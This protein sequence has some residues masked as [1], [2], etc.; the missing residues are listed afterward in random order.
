MFYEL[1]RF[2][3]RLYYTES[4]IITIIMTGHYYC[5][6]ILFS[7]IAICLDF[8]VT[9]SM[10]LHHSEICFYVELSFI[11]EFYYTELEVIAIIRIIMTGILLKFLLDFML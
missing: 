8:A 10:A 2:I 9:D 3:Q 11:Q 1:L 4:H 6:L 5:I 7:A